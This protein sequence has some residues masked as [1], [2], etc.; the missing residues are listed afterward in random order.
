MLCFLPIPV[1]SA[2]ISV[3]RRMIE[4]HVVHDILGEAIAAAVT[5]RFKE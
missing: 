3:M 1:T 2:A 4:E 5:G